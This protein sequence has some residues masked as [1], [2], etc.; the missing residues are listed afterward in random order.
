MQLFGATLAKCKALCVGS[1]GCKG[2]EFQP[3]GA[4]RIF[5]RPGGIDATAEKPGHVCLRYGATQA[6]AKEEGARVGQVHLAKEPELCL[7]F[8]ALVDSTPL[9]VW[10]CVNSTTRFV[11]GG[12]AT[13]Q[14]RLYEAPEKCVEVVGGVRG[15]A[16]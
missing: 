14:I 9:R 4:C 1:P 15:A 2:L 5:T 8:A 13:A 7:D 6:G 10:P 16:A 12:D 3:S 11:M